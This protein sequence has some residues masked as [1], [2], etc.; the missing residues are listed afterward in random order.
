MERLIDWHRRT[1]ELTGKL[2]MHGQFAYLRGVSTE[3]VLHILV[4]RMEKSLESKHVAIAAFLDIEG[5]FSQ[6]TSLSLME[7][8]KRRF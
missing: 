2:K 7:A 4:A 6:A 1:P 3:A 8:L 5:A